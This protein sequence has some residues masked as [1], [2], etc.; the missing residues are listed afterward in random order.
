LRHRLQQGCAFDRAESGHLTQLASV[1]S[2]VHKRG[3]ADETETRPRPRRRKGEGSEFLQ[4]MPH[5]LDCLR[6]L[7]GSARAREGSEWIADKLRVPDEKREEMN[8]NR[9]KRFY[10]QVAWGRQ[11]LI[12]EGLLE[13]SKR[14]VWALT[15]K[16]QQTHLSEAFTLKSSLRVCSALLCE[17]TPAHQRCS[18]RQPSEEAE[19]I[20]S[21]RWVGE[22]A[23]E[24]N[25][26]RPGVNFAVADGQS[27]RLFPEP[28]ACAWQ[29]V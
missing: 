1:A 29:H 18:T 12:W 22:K 19:G 2:V 5:I 16:G 6:A 17:A 15:E 14:G 7:G 20:R 28:L 11:F 27:R 8:K 4:W 25:E 10:N 9:V 13:S 26:R 21:V 24:C 3:M 23:S